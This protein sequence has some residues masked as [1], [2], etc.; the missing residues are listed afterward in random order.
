MSNNQLNISRSITMI[1]PRETSPI[2][3]SQVDN[4]DY[5]KRDMPA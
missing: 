4:Q 5:N 2:Q 3:F 1:V